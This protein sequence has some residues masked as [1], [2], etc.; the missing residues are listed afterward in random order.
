MFFTGTGGSVSRIGR[1][2]FRLEVALDRSFQL[3]VY[4][5]GSDGTMSLLFPFPESGETSRLPA[6]T[7]VLPQDRQYSYKALGPLGASRFLA[8]LTPEEN[9]VFKAAREKARPTA[10]EVFSFERAAEQSNTQRW[11]ASEVF[12]ATEVN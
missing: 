1:D 4:Q 3:Y 12:S 5:A 10:R 8:V 2:H 9:D 11:A 7:H 6:G